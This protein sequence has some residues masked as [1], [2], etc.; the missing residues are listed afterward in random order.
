MLSTIVPMSTVSTGP[1]GHRQLRQRVAER[2]RSDILDGRLCPGEWLRQE[3]LAQEQGV[4]QTPVREALKELVSEGLVEHVPYRGIRV[5]QFSVEDAEDLYTCRA[6]LE[7]MAARHAALGIG[8][9]NVRKLASL[10]E[11]MVRCKVPGELRKYRELNRQFHE[12]IYLASRR[13]YLVRTL[14]QLWSAFPTMLW[15]NVPRTAVASA[16]G[17]DE[18]DAEEHAEIVAAF[19]ARDPA[20]AERAVGHHIEMAGRAIVAAMKCPE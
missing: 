16:P 12:V 4:S 7:G 6:V 9:A 14:G 10:H 2:L 8:D 18:P 11:R 3:R 20:R 15:S 5:V 19:E 1:P 17:R 13:A